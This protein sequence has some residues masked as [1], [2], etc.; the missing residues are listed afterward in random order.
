M[1]KGTAVVTG[2]GQGIGKGIAE[3]LAKD[4]FA[5]V[6]GDLNEEVLKGTVKEFEQAGY[7]VAY[8]VGD[9][10]KPEDQK[11]LVH[12]AVNTFGSTDVFVNNAGVAHVGPVLELKEQN[13]DLLFKVN[14]FGTVYGIQA[15]AEQMKQQD[16]GGKIINAC[17][18]AGHQSFPM[19]GLYSATKFAVRGF[20]Q[21]AA[22]E[23][24]QFNIKVNAYCPGIVGT[25][26]W[27]RIDD[28][29]TNYQGIKKGEAFKKAI[30]SIALGRPEKPE[31]IANF[32]S[33]LASSDSDY[34]TGQSILID[35]GIVFN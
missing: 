32:V 19:M 26:M 7:Q 30:E 27:E 35:G 6:L 4:G 1:S 21:A 31:D 22:K 29:M 33:F 12:Q 18:I 8:F 5:V 9:V 17:S 24:A 20:T 10:T 15:A 3:R 13:L 14:V 23:L 16:N 28:V 34:I 2:S 11:A 25:G